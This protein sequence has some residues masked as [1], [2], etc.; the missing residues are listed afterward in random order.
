MKRSSA[1][2][3]DDLSLTDCARNGQ[4]HDPD[5][6]QSLVKRLFPYG[7][8]PNKGACKALDAFLGRKAPSP[9][10][11]HSCFLWC[12][13]H[14][15]PDIV[16]FMQSKW[17]AFSGCI[18]LMSLPD[19][20]AA[21]AITEITSH[22]IA[23]T[24]RL[25]VSDPAMSLHLATCLASPQCAI[26]ELILEFPAWH[27]PSDGSLVAGL[28]HA[29]AACSSIRHL[30]LR[31]PEQGKCELETGF[32]TDAMANANL[33]SVSLDTGLA[34]HD[35]AWPVLGQ[36]ILDR[37]LA[38]D[39]RG[40]MSIQLAD[41]YAN[42]IALNGARSGNKAE[43][44]LSTVWRSSSAKDLVLAQGAKRGSLRTELTNLKYVAHRPS[45]AQYLWLG[46]ESTDAADA[47]NPAAPNAP[48]GERYLMLRLPNLPLEEEPGLLDFLAGIGPVC[49]H[50][51]DFSSVLRC[52]VDHDCANVVYAI[53]IRYPYFTGPIFAYESD[54]EMLEA[55]HDLGIAFDLY[56]F[57]DENESE[58]CVEIAIKTLNLQRVKI[59]TV[60]FDW[61]DED[62]ASFKNLKM[63]LQAVATTP[64]VVTVKLHLGGNDPE[65]QLSLLSSALSLKSIEAVKFESTSTQIDCAELMA[66][67]KQGVCGRLQKLSIRA[68]DDVLQTCVEAIAAAGPQCRLA[69]LK[70]RRLPAADACDIDLGLLLRGQ[71]SISTLGLDASIVRAYGRPDFVDAVHGSPSIATLRF[72][73]DAGEQMTQ[74]LSA[75]VGPHLKI[76]HERYSEA[77]PA[78]LK[79][80]VHLWSGEW[81]MSAAVADALQGMLRSLEERDIRSL[82]ATSRSMWSAFRTTPAAE[83][84]IDE[85]IASAKSFVEEDLRWITRQFELP[86]RTD[87]RLWLVGQ[88][89]QGLTGIATSILSEEIHVSP[90]VHQP[91]GAQDPD[92][93]Q[94][95]Q[96]MVKTDMEPCAAVRMAMEGRQPGRDE[97]E[98]CV[99]WCGE[100]GCMKIVAAIQRRW[101]AFSDLVRLDGNKKQV[102]ML[103]G[104]L[105]HGIACDVTVT[106]CSRDDLDHLVS[107]LKAN[108]ANR[109]LSIV[110]SL[111]EM[112]PG[113]LAQELAKTKLRGL[114]LLGDGKPVALA[115]DFLP[116]LLRS[117]SIEQFTLEG[118][119]VTPEIAVHEARRWIEQ[120]KVRSL[121]V[122]SSASLVDL[123]GQAVVAADGKILDLELLNTQQDE[124]IFSWTRHLFHPRL[125]IASLVLDENQLASL[126]PWQW[127]EV[128][129]TNHRLRE[130]RAVTADPRRS[131]LSSKAAQMVMRNRAI[132]TQA[133]R[134]AVE[135]F[136]RESKLAGSF[137]ATWVNQLSAYVAEPGSFAALRRVN[138]ATA[139]AAREATESPK[140]VHDAERLALVMNRAGLPGNGLLGVD[141]IVNHLKSRG[142]ASLTAAQYARLRLA[143]VD[144]IERYL[145]L[146][147]EGKLPELDIATA[148]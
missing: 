108:E 134:L 33:W 109:T 64:S 84:T 54:W 67:I 140:V 36:R 30:T 73:S 122:R 77:V 104:I 126:T 46:Q 18:D 65:D 95:V 51:D 115:P 40:S 117:E 38:R 145:D 25:A 130:L 59:R 6:D 124:K 2:L 144:R 99:V 72:F 123:F 29:V 119:F 132:Q 131:V 43:L 97:F 66:V 41:A 136:M 114:C 94:Q 80:L 91:E 39:D 17:Q 12:V 35:D 90:P 113:S 133:H 9:S 56:V 143:V 139:N 50:Y 47:E 28:G 141:R 148:T 102:W 92:L 106:I 21:A 121:H 26:F 83:K 107:A 57:G 45:E 76:N 42:A 137:Q 120:S 142:Y 31:G 52:C 93:G 24:L 16:T 53:Q 111:E 55:V 112:V 44:G 75:A 23:C 19:S 58:S 7:N 98:A 74:A 61:A 82:A 34:W 8:V 20:D 128:V 78:M 125:G 85:L 37:M 71:Q 14:G 100:M 70:L 127:D 3:S 87:L 49:K 79:S 110:L 32:I 146:W 103:G 1:A 11:F 68:N 101:P 60:A 147:Q 13:Q 135:T 10:D 86:L 105:S 63:M 138:R 88:L 15:R 89:R 118:E 116:E 69:K 27:R 22:R 129:K 62:D 81:H 4:A 5:V 48:G 96:S